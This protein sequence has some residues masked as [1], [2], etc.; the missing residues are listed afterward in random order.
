MQ[1]KK[2]C[3]WVCFWWW[4]GGGYR[5]NCSL[6]SRIEKRNICLTLHIHIHV[7][8]LMSSHYNHTICFEIRQ[9]PL[10]MLRLRNFQGISLKNL[11]EC[12]PEVNYMSPVTINIFLSMSAV[13]TVFLQSLFIVSVTACGKLMKHY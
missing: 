1:K 9:M 10:R 7:N 11:L 6:F 3:L 2:C 4:G 5:E 13:K 12:Y 8:I